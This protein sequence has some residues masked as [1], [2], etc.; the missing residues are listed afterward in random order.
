AGVLG[1][2]PIAIE[3]GR[4]PASTGLPVVRGPC[5][6]R[7][8]CQCPAPDGCLPPPQRDAP[9]HGGCRNTLRLCP[10][11][12]CVPCCYRQCAKR[13]RCS[14]QSWTRI[15][16]IVFPPPPPS[17]PTFDTAASSPTHSRPPPRP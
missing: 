6:P 5:A 12:L 2:C 3:A 8:S 7:I 10:A 11:K 1:G 17:S 9:G 14:V 16:D 15:Q 4:G 13:Y